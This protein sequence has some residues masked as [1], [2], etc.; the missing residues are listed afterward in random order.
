MIVA[1]AATASTTMRWLPV[2]VT[3]L[4]RRRVPV[5]R[6]CQTCERTQTP[7]GARSENG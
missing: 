6:G 3:S 7:G 4:T 5:T 1:V 2:A